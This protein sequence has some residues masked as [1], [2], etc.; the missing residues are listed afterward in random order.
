MTSADATENKAVE[1]AAAVP[2]KAVDAQL[3]DE[4]VQHSLQRRV[5]ATCAP[6]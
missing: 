5:T 2:E 1:S 4:L 6:T 3:I